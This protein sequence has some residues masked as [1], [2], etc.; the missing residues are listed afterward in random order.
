AYRRVL[1]ALDPALPQ[2]PAVLR[3]GGLAPF[4]E[5]LYGCSEM[6]NEGFRRLVEAGVIRRKVVDDEAL[7]RRI[8]DGTA[9]LG[10]RA[11][12]ERDGEFLHGAFYLGSHDFYDWLRNLPEEQR[13]GIGMRRIS[14]I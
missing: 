9:N 13:R 12:L 7:M 8:A 4:A 2:H 1:G 5:G 6:L 11:R 3:S 10:D 14:E